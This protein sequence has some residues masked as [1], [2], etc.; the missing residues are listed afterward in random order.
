M[1]LTGFD[2]YHLFLVVYVFEV[3]GNHVAYIIELKSRSLNIVL[4][5]PRLLG[6][7]KRIRLP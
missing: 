6:F 4:R 3:D 5:L 2:D 7:N 1:P